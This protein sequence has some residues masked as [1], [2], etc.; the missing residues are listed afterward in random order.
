MMH[1]PTPNNLVIPDT[2]C[3]LNGTFCPLR[4]A[5]ISVLDR[6]FIF[7]DGVYEVVPVYQGMPFRFEHHM[8]RLERSLLEL[9]IANPYSVEHWRELIRNLV[10]QFALTSQTPLVE[11]SQIVYIQISRGVAPRDHIMPQGCVPTVFMMSNAFK[12]IAPEVRAAGVR[13][14]TADDFRWEKAHIKST[15]LLGAVFARQIS[16]DVQATETIMFRSN[17]LSEAAASNVWLVKDGEVLAPPKNNLLLEGIR[18]GLIQEICQSLN[19]PF[20]LR[21]ISKEEVF[22]ADEVLLSS[23]SKEILAVSHIDGLAVGAHTNHP[24]APGPVYKALF[25]EY[26]QFIKQSCTPHSP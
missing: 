23:A 10:E 14:V 11:S 6:G 22:G 25:A 21:K 5:K 17:Y 24:G 4:E 9:R 7:G 12:P 13:C 15:S 18:Y 3:F 20:I 16:A 26:Q 1:T 2:V 19:V 8:A